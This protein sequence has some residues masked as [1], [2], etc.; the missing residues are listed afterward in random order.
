MSYWRDIDNFLGKQ[1]DGDVRA[2]EDLDAISNSLVNIFSTFQG[3]RRMLPEFALPIYRIL[4]EPIDELTARQLG[5]M[6]FESITRWETRITVENIHVEAD[7]DR[8]L[9]KILLIY[10][11]AVSTETQN[12]ETIL[13]VI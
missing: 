3:S 5:E 1:N 9:Y 2:M 12:F 8:N 13:R 7:E 6:V 10:R 11:V 4:F